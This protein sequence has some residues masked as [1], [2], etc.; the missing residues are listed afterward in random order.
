MLIALSALHVAEIVVSILLM[1]ASSQRV[2]SLCFVWIVS[3]ILLSIGLVGVLVYIQ[4]PHSWIGIII[5]PFRLYFIWI[6]W[7]LAAEILVY[8]KGPPVRVVVRRQA[9]SPG[10]TVVVGSP[11]YSYGYSPYTPYYGGY[12]GGYGYPYYDPYYDVGMGVGLGLGYGLG[13]YGYDYG[14]GG[15]DYGY[16]YDSFGGGYY[17]SAF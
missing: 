12:Y 6:V 9:G 10:T 1:A 2:R 4:S 8:P 5:I 13:G 11:V 15:Y 7:A 14:Y 3:I 16:G 17:D